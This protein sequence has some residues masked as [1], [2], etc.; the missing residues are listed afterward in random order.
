MPRLEGLLKAIF[1]HLSDIHFGQEKDGGTVVI[2]DDAKARLIE[3]ARAEVAK[4]GG[5]A[6]GVIVTGD[7]A[8]SGKKEEYQKA[9]GWLGELT[10]AIGCELI[11]VQMVPGNH[12]IDRD[13]ISATMSC[14]LFAIREGGHQFL[15]PLLDSTDDCKILYG[16][17]EAYADFALDYQSELDL[18]GGILRVDGWSWPMADLSVLC[19]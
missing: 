6:A 11:D 8:Y 1:I 15:D 7:I 9:A 3:D 5:K 2:N 4:L 19:G 13:K 16:R 14:I 18:N 12:D 10:N 17:F